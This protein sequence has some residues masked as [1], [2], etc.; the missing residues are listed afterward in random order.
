MSTNGVVQARCF[1]NIQSMINVIP[2][3]YCYPLIDPFLEHDIYSNLHGHGQTRNQLGTPGGAKSFP[4]GT[5]IFST[6]S[7]IFKLCPTHLSRG[8]H[9][10]RGASPPL[11]LLG[12]GPGHGQFTLHC[13]ISVFISMLVHVNEN[14]P[15]KIFFQ[16]I[17][18]FFLLA[19]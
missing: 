16:N 9:F 15:F 10:S 13:I 14:M 5:Q 17:F 7:N 19:G 2:W 12:Y 8:K 1:T 18:S 6:M 4:R 3:K 11:R